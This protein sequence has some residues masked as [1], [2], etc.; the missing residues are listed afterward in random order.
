M[1]EIYSEAFGPWPF[2]KSKFALVETS[3]WGMEHSTAVAYGSSYPA[4]CKEHE[5]EDRYASRNTFF[6]YIL[7]H[8]S[9]HEWWGNAVSAE[10]WG[11][12][13]IHEGFGT[14]A[15]GVYVEKLQGRERAD[16]YFAGQA[17]RSLN[18]DGSLYRGDD[19]KSGKAYSGLIYYKGARVLNTLRHYVDDD[20]AWWDTLRTFN[21]SHR[22]G[23]ADTE[24]FRAVLEE[25][26]KR[27]W[28]R[29]FDEWFYGAGVPQVKGTITLTDSQIRLELT[30]EG[31]GETS[32]HVPLDLAW[33][34]GNET[35]TRRVWLA[36]G[37]H[38]SEISVSAAVTE[39][40]VRHLN[41]VL[42]LH[43]VKVQP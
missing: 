42:G 40:R 18:S 20:D 41:R 1:L 31:N 38:E 33:N 17:R 2:P 25:R 36:P 23:N 26:T 21:L 28:K 15:E 34:A 35:V 22:Y 27:D 9:A 11:H 39:L 3:F 4:W 37:I 5:E 29:F 43:D 8:E 13:W 12:F 10:H 14:Y 30:N 7:I 24:D 32:F 19:P 16:E 6:D